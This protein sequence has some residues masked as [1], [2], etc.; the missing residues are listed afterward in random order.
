MKNNFVL[1][2]TLTFFS[3]SCFSQDFWE[4]IPTPDTLNTSD[5]ACKNDGTLFISN[6]EQGGVYRSLDQ[7]NTWQLAGFNW[8]TIG[9]IAVNPA[10]DDVFV[11]GL[12]FNLSPHSGIFKSSD[13]GINW[14]AVYLPDFSFDNI[15][16]YRC[17]F[18]SIMIAGAVRYIFRSADNGQ[19]WDVAHFS[20]ATNYVEVFTDFAFSPDGIIYATSARM[21]SDCGK[22]WRSLDTGLTWEEIGG[23]NYFQSI[24]IDSSGKILFGGEGLYRYDPL[25][26]VWEQLLPSFYYPDDIIVAPNQNI[27]IGCNRNGISIGGVLVSED[28]GQTFTTINSGIDWIDVKRLK[29]D[30]IGRLLVVN[31]DVLRSTDTL[32]THTSFNKSNNSSRLLIYPNPVESYFTVQTPEIFGTKIIVSIYSI[33]GIKLHEETVNN[34]NRIGFPTGLRPGIYIV[35]AQGARYKTTASI[36]FKPD[37]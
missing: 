24:A 8:L 32:I 2:L 23:C 10:T 19:T 15:R 20:N 13:N 29:P 35:T 12:D 6:F 11:Q 14:H 37:F 16:Q 26:E 7:G 27:Y 31:S 1:I 22:L 21:Y 18:D 17:G 3:L 28:N 5:I 36:I 30:N 34:G 25:T 4:M 33:T 9:S